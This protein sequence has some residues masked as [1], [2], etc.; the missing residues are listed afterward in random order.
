MCHAVHHELAAV[1]AALPAK[2]GLSKKE[3]K[4]IEAIIAGQAINRKVH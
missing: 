4:R 2:K 3:L 1:L